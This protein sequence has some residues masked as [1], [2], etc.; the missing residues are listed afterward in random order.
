MVWILQHQFDAS[1]D[2]VI[3]W[4]IFRAFK[5]KRLEGSQA[6]LVKSA[7]NLV[8]MLVDTLCK[9]T[10]HSCCC[11]GEAGDWEHLEQVGIELC[12]GIL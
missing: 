9:P 4:G 1:L 6:I 3:Y 7:S 5:L 12:K 8:E 2:L 10:T 11:Q